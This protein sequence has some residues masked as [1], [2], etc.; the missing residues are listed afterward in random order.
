MNVLLFGDNVTSWFSSNEK[1]YFN[2]ND[3]AKFIIAYYKEL[4]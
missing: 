3:E 4:R 2:H 1:L